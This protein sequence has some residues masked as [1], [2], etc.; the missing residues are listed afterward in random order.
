[1]F[2]IGISDVLNRIDNL[3]MVPWASPVDV[4]PLSNRRQLAKREAVG[5]MSVGGSAVLNVG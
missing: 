1:M 4:L 2:R 3:S 5:E